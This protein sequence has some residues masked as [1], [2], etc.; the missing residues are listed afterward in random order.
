MQFPV[1]FTRHAA[2]LAGPWIPRQ[3]LGKRLVIK[4][5]A[6]ISNAYSKSV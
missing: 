4:A 2:Y 6:R 5:I 1:L 3:V